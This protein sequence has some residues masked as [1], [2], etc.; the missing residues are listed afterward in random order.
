MGLYQMKLLKNSSLA[1]FSLSFFLLHADF[2]DVSVWQ[3]LSDKGNE[4]HLVLCGDNH[5]LKE[6]GIDQAHEIV[7]CLAK[8]ANKYDTILVEDLNDMQSLGKSID[9]F[10]DAYPNSADRAKA[11]AFID[12]AG[13]SIECQREECLRSKEH[14]VLFVLPYLARTKN[15]SVQNIDFRFIVSCSAM[16]L[17]TQ[18]YADGRLLVP[19]L[20]ESIV[21][22]IAAYN[23]GPLLNNIYAKIIGRYTPFKDVVCDIMRSNN[24]IFQDLVD[25][26]EQTCFDNPAFKPV[27]VHPIDTVDLSWSV[28]R[29]ERALENIR[30]G[31][32]SIDVR[33][34]F[35]SHLDTLLTLSSAELIDAR[36]L[37]AI[38][39]RQI[40][41]SAGNVMFMCAGKAHNGVIA[42]V[43]PNFGY[44][45][46]EHAVDKN[47]VDISQLCIALQHS[48]KDS[49]TVW[50]YITDA[51]SSVVQYVTELFA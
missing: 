27:Y 8:R 26:F 37:H 39:T 16:R 43:L 46:I 44:T 21:E 35:R 51:A 10:F 9:A 5:D 49:I 11:Q 34:Q 22:E 42:Q 40:Q 50:S 2:V 7:D 12:T 28:N 6:T 47:G 41:S 24:I 38:Y 15:V 48:S 33:N 19:H 25:Y 13:K 31:D 14:D 29:F 17:D 23:D 3:R 1:V 45:L 18:K 32:K 36:A 30:N 4:Q 20:I